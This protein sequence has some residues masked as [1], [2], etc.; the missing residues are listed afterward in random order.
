[1]VDLQRFVARIHWNCFR[2]FS[3]I[4]FSYDFMVV[5]RPS[6]LLLGLPPLHSSCCLIWCVQLW[7]HLHSCLP[8]W[9]IHDTQSLFLD[10]IS[11]RKY[12]QVIL[13]ALR[14]NSGYISILYIII[15]GF[16][17]F[18]HVRNHTFRTIV[19]MPPRS[20]SMLQNFLWLPWD[21]SIYFP[22]LN[23]F[24]FFF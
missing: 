9:P 21:F 7:R 22:A 17:L 10:R 8:K 5:L 11:F 14:T 3:T 12:P 20:L 15:I 23:F 16:L 2:F 24:A 19:S 4:V 13:C 18:L 1:M 6:S